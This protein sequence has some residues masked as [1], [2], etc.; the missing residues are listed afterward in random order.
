MPGA[1]KQP[2]CRPTAARSVGA[3]RRQRDAGGQQSFF[4]RKARSKYA[5][6]LFH[7][8]KIVFI[9]FFNSQ[10]ALSMFFNMAAIKLAA[11]RGSR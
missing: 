2:R 1:K 8:M 11:P 6:A 5:A 4:A 9:L 3:G 7:N 10:S